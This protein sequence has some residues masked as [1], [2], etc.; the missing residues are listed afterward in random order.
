MSTEEARA[1]QS[2]G[3]SQPSTATGAVFLSYA[4]EDGAAA[5]RIAAALRAAGIEVWFDKS[6]LRGGDAWDRQIRKQIHDC[7]LF[8]PVIS[9]SSDARREGYFRRE[10]RL[11]VE[12]AGDM[13]ERVAFLVPVVIDDTS[14]SR[15][16]VPDRFREVQ[17]TRL[18]AGETPPEFL[19]G[20]RRM[21]A[22]PAAVTGATAPAE[23]RVSS[24]SAPEK[25]LAVMPFANLSPDPEN[26]YFSDGLAEEI[27][28]ALSGL[29]ELRV[30]ARRSS[31]Y[32]KGRA[33]DPQEIARRLRV[34]HIVEGSVRRSGNRVRVMAQLVDLRNGFQLWSERYDRELA[35]VFEIQ[36]EIAR[37]IAGRLKVAL[38]T[39]A[40]RPTAN[41]EAYEQYLQG[42][43]HV[44][45]RTPSSLRAAIQRFERCIA[46]DSEYALAH[47]ALTQ[48]YA[49]SAWWAMQSY[50]D[51]RPRAHAAASKAMEIAPELCECNQSQG[52]YSMAFECNWREAGR[53]FK[54]ALEIN[55]REP[56]VHVQHAQ[57]SAVLGREA[58]AMA[59]AEAACKLDPL[60]PVMH[61]MGSFVM[62]VLERFAEAEAL[63]RQALELQ[64]DHGLAL[65][66]HAFAASGLGRHEEA[67][68]EMERAV[69]LYRT[70]IATGE[71]GLFYGRA[72]RHEDARRLLQE[73]DD[74]AARGEFTV[75][76]AR[77]LLELGSNQPERVRDAFTAAL[78]D[79]IPAYIIRMLSGPFL[80]PYRR[81]PEVD[82]L[83]RK[84]YG[85]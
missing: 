81:D 63:A 28:N 68:S 76:V 33:T 22:G 3:T 72:G 79:G 17:W 66:R 84:L 53:H 82:R 67:I 69:S 41:L 83:H 21:L 51:A 25:S 42:H 23:A 11:A 43:H 19:A 27:L 73:L 61:A 31:F 7:A 60:A 4:S 29:T 48:C 10:W 64:P 85:W 57:L 75:S 16:D 14:E 44:N 9:A 59:H 36:D 49:L 40:R 18:T 74:R 37:A 71:L 26:E 45:Q 5:E 50:A 52:L 62:A 78:A 65:V 38:L 6:E 35:D 8:V 24:E 1:S 13:S 2:S 15:A 47:A 80:Q 39:G 34:A 32:F 12:R 46:L 54:R 77:L 56:M 58:E 70:P 30:A 20:V 55:P